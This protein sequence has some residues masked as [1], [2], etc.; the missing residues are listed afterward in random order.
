V[1]EESWPQSGVAAEVAMRIMEAA[2]DHLEAGRAGLRQR[3]DALCRQ[4]RKLA[5]PSVDDGRRR[6]RSVT[7]SAHAVIR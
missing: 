4:S 7:G 3:P 1:V 6:A 5:L 2:F